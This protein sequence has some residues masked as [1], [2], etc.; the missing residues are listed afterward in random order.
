MAHW[1][2]DDNLTDV[3]DGFVGVYTDPNILIDATGLEVFDSSS[4]SGQ[5]LNLRDTNRFVVVTGSGSHFNF[6]TQG[7][8]IAC[9]INAAS[10]DGWQIAVSKSMADKSAGYSLG[11]YDGQGF[12]NI[13]GTNV[14]TDYQG[15]TVTVDGW[16]LVVNQYDPASATY[17]IF[18]DGLKVDESPVITGGVPAGTIEV[19]IGAEGLGAA[20]INSLIDELSMWNYVVDPYTIA[21]DYV[22]VM[23]DEAVCVNQIGLEYDLSGP[24]GEPDCVVNF[25]DFVEYAATWFSCNRV[26]GTTS[27]LVDCN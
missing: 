4:I 21:E 10:T 5:S 25:Y 12:G 23:T 17:K 2:F 13:L 11:L 20:P 26:A 15:G 16:H 27:G 1:N 8:T 3:V 19:V 22:A 18:V 9:W 24:T 14:G 7:F 6:Y